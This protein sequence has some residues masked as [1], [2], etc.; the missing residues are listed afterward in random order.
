MTQTNLKT[1][2][3]RGVRRR[4]LTLI[5]SQYIK[6]GHKKKTYQKHCPCE[7]LQ[8]QGKDVFGDFIWMAEKNE[9]KGDAFVWSANMKNRR[10]KKYKQGCRSSMINGKF[11][12]D[13]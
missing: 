8:F 6:S 2:T 10:T 1:H 11:V 13:R 9:Y 7:W 3:V 4:R 12:G 5:N